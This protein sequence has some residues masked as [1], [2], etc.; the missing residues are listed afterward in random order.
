[1]QDSI[2]GGSSHTA[3]LSKSYFD[4]RLKIMREFLR[5]RLLF[6]KSQKVAATGYYDIEDS[7]PN[8]N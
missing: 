6:F 2:R 3:V 8:V 4:L 1:M 5:K 7:V